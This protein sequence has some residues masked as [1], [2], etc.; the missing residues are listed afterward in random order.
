MRKPT[1]TIFKWIMGMVL[2]ALFPVSIL[3]LFYPS[4]ERIAIGMFVMLLIYHIHKQQE[5]I[6]RLEARA[7]GFASVEDMDRK[8][9]LLKE[10]V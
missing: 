4:L 2:V 8:M 5:K 3:T 1:E 7:G 9:R 6:K 10:L